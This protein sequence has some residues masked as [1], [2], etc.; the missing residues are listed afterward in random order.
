MF[1]FF[2]KQCPVCKAELGENTVKG[3][4]KEFDSENCKEIFSKQLASAQSSS[5]GGCCH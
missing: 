2:K 5:K 3:F 1:N 4:G